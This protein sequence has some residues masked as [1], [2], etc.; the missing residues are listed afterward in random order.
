MM[1]QQHDLLKETVEMHCQKMYMMSD[2]KQFWAAFAKLWLK[3]IG[4]GWSLLFP[5][6]IQKIA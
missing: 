5:V 2:V 1:Y 6:N 3:M 4:D